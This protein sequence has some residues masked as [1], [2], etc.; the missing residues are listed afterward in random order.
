M[1]SLNSSLVCS[2]ED[3]VTLEG[4]V[5]RLSWWLHALEVGA[6]VQVQVQVQVQVIEALLTGCRSDLGT[7]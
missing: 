3:N 2:R 7:Q 4:R 6:E 1:S 5:G